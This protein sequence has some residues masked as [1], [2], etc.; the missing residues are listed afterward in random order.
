MFL[1]PRPH[2]QE[3]HVVVDHNLCFFCGACVAICPPDSIFL[4]NTHLNIDDETCTRCERCVHM[5]PVHAL[6]M[7][8]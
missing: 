6:S 2:L 3:R 5:C 8:Q 7:E 4:D 1:K